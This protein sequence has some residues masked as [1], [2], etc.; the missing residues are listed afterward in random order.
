MARMRFLFLVSLLLLVKAAAGAGMDAGIRILIS[1]DSPFSS[2]LGAKVE[3]L[4]RHGETGS[5][6]GGAIP[7]SRPLAVA[8]G[9]KAFRQALDTVP[10]DV[11]LIG[12]AVPSA[13][14]DVAVRTR[15]GPVGGVYLEMPLSRWG[16]L[17]QVAFPARKAVG[18]LVTPQL[19]SK[20]SRLEALLSERSIRLFSERVDRESDVG[21]AVERLTQNVVLLLATP[22]PLVYSPNSVQPL[23]LTTYRSGVPVVAFSEAYLRAG[24]T[25]ALFSTVDQLALQ[26]TELIH[27]VREGRAL[28]LPTYPRYY[29]VGVNATVAR[30]L[31]IQMPSAQEIEARMSQMR[32]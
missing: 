5:G 10:A 20:V 11:A 3:S 16:N 14:L 29:S 9:S 23:L 2:Q 12:I 21:G 4:L 27:G 25:A 24:A 17:I 18:V 28:S 6:S 8:I 31:G 32:E 19:Q 15:G 7:S 26:A 30:S 13:Q 22:D 1:E